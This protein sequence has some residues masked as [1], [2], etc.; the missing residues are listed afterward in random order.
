[1]YLTYH[2]IEDM[3]ALYEIVREAP[4]GQLVRFL[5]KNKLFKYQEELPGFQIPWQ[6][7]IKDEK[8]QFMRE[9]SNVSQ[10]PNPLGEE[11]KP[12]IGRGQ[13]TD[14]EAL[15]QIPTLRPTRTIDRAQQTSKIRRST[16]VA[17]GAAVELTLVQIRARLRC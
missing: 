6:Q 14:L 5:T 15:S 10:E 9:S 13:S 4:F 17:S 11:E 1:M 7:A 8:E 16:V 2:I 12:Q 3:G